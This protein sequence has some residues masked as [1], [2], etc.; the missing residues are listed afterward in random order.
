MVKL[1]PNQRVEATADSA[2]DLPLEFL[3]RVSHS[4]AVPHAL[5]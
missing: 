2:L 5:R 1:R 3:T 4:L